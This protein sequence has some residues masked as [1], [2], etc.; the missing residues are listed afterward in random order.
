V[1]EEEKKMPEAVKGVYEEVKE[2]YEEVKGIV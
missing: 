1:N 2:E